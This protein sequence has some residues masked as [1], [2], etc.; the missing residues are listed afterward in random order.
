MRYMKI[1]EDFEW[2]FDFE[3]EPS[4]QIGD[5]IM[6][7]RHIDYWNIQDKK[8]ITVRLG[9]IHRIVKDIKQ[10]SELNIL[11]YDGYMVF[12][13]NAANY[14]CFKMEDMKLDEKNTTR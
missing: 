9:N 13:S 8:W 4:I 1:Y 3:E 11:N 7:D 2:D 5:N 14:V 12:L 6:M 10:S